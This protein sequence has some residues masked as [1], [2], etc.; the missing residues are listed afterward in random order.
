MIR[1]SPASARD[2]NLYRCLG[3]GSGTDLSRGSHISVFELW[4]SWPI[5]WRQGSEGRSWCRYLSE[6]P[7]TLFQNYELMVLAAV[8]AMPRSVAPETGWGA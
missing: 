4:Q 5:G 6:H 1:V 7:K 2:S 8:V 3:D